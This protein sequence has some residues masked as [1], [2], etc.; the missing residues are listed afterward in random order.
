MNLLRKYSVG[1]IGAVLLTQM[2]SASVGYFC[3][4]EDSRCEPVLW[5]I[6]NPIIGVCGLGTRFCKELP[7][8]C[9]L[10]YDIDEAHPL[11]VQCRL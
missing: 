2:S 11:F 8:N 10:V 5:P 6:N 7:P 9:E 3:W 4:P 1:F